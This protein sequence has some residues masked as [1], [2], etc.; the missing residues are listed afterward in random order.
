MTPTVLIVD[1]SEF[2]RQA[3]GRA[4]N[5]GEQVEIVVAKNGKEALDILVSNKSVRVMILDVDMP[6]LDGREVLRRLD[7]KT[8]RS[9]FVIAV[10]NRNDPTTLEE[11]RQL[12]A[13]A[14]LT[15]PIDVETLCSL[16]RPR[17]NRSETAW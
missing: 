12:G 10:G 5:A 14:T 7:E 13:H 15:K 8:S 4:L 6:I 1:D 17:I 9:L 2:V 11:C 16:V 3:L